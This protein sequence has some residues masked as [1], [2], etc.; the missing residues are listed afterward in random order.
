[1]AQKARKNNGQQQNSARAR[2]PTPTPTQKNSAFQAE[3][4]SGARAPLSVRPHATPAL[5]LVGNDEPVPPV[6]ER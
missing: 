6:D 3:S 2:D 1:M 5:R 4:S